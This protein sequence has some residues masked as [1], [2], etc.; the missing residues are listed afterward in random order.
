MRG[1][2]SLI[3][4]ASLASP[5]F[6]CSPIWRPFA[7]TIDA[8]ELT[9]R[10]VPTIAYSRRETDR[11]G[12]FGMAGTLTLAKVRCIQRPKGYSPCP[13]TITVAFSDREDGSSCPHPLR[14]NPDRLRYFSLYFQDG[15]WRV[16]HAARTFRGRE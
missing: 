16:G 12:Y 4:A 2:L 8:D 3:I 1:L 9:V 13:D 14:S 11:D 6:A 5:A 7:E 15:E 10:A